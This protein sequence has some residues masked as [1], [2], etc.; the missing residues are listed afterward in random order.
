MR[1]F[2]SAAFVAGPPEGGSK[3]FEYHLLA[4]FPER[5]RILGIQ[6]I[7][8]DPLAVGAEL[9]AVRNDRAD[10]A[11]LAV[12]SPDLLGGRGDGG[13]YGGR[14]ALRD[15]LPLEQRLAC[16]GEL[17]VQLLDHLLLLGRM[18]VAADLRLNAAGVHGRGAH[19]AVAMP[20]V[21]P[22]GKQDVRSLRTA[23]SPVGLIRHSLEIRIV[24]IDVG[25]AVAGRRQADHPA[26]WADQ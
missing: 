3:G 8:A 9:N 12:A 5:L 14:R 19:A 22:H 6:R 24:E 16:R 20:S 1:I 26:P 17:P 15:R 13:P 11:I 7:S 10:M 21:K 4:L 2:L 18:R 23:I 25:D